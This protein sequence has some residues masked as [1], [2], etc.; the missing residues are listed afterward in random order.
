[1]I[2]ALDKAGHAQCWVPPPSP[3]TSAR[4]PHSLGLQ[5]ATLFD[6]GVTL[7]VRFRGELEAMV[8]Y[9]AS[10]LETSTAVCIVPVERP[11]QSGSRATAS[12]PLLDD[13]HSRELTVRLDRPLGARV[14]VGYGG[15]P[16]TVISWTSSSSRPQSR[17]VCHE[18]PVRRT[19]CGATK[20]VAPTFASTG[21][22]RGA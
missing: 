17:V 20:D 4:R 12:W 1:M 3:D 10:V 22:D 2:W 7:R 8:A 18:P 6:D 5:R 11:L 21:S 15:Y 13:S 16:V 19:P 9:D 14:L